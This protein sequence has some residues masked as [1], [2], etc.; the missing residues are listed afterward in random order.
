MCISVQRGV[1]SC[2]PV[3]LLSCVLYSSLPSVVLINRLVTVVHNIVA[4][5]CKRGVIRIRREHRTTTPLPI[6][7][8][9]Q[10][11]ITLFTSVRTI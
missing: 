9:Y 4:Y 11:Y 3:I 10:A 7:I 6:L 1:L 8:W 5:V 2:Y